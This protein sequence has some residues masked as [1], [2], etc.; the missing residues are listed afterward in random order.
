MIIYT[1]F[2]TII[3]ISIANIYPF[4]YHT[5][6]NDIIEYLYYSQLII[7]PAIIWIIY[8]WNRNKRFSSIHPAFISTLII[9]ITPFVSGAVGNI[10]NDYIAKRFKTLQKNITIN[11]FNDNLFYSEKG[12]AIG[13][14]INIRINSP[15]S[16]RL[17]PY[18]TLKSITQPGNI[19]IPRYPE[20]RYHECELKNAKGDIILATSCKD[21]HPSVYANIT[22]SKVKLNAN[23][24]YIFSIKMVPDNCVSKT[25]SLAD[26]GKPFTPSDFGLDTPVNYQAEINLFRH[27]R[28]H[29]SNSSYIT[30]GKYLPKDM[31]KNLTTHKKIICH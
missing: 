25:Y 31:Y 30:K 3:S 23:E 11:D 1:I 5:S 2:L 12:K 7:A 16:I 10:A 20:F 13:I 9:I 19:L 26:F 24:S 21:L 18:I 28:K 27:D 29:L 4:A 14:I 17:Y 8:F 22:W 6:I 15:D